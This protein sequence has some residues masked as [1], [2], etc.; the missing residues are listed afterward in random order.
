MIQQV[1]GYSLCMTGIAA[2]CAASFVAGMGIARYLFPPRDG[3]GH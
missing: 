1:I 2:L 3:D